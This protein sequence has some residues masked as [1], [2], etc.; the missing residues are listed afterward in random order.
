MH[1]E[2]A[3]ASATTLLVE[4]PRAT[5]C[6]T[7]APTAGGRTTAAARPRVVIRTACI[8]N[9]QVTL[10]RRSLNWSTTT[11]INYICLGGKC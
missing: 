11:L 5:A 3:Y 8:C 9:Q 4:A 2:M 1:A 6:C 7:H 10:P